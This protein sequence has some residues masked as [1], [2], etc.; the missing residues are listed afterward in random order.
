MFSSKFVG[1]KKQ[2]EVA[3]RKIEAMIPFGTDQH[4]RL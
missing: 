1:K 4:P 3:T 2:I